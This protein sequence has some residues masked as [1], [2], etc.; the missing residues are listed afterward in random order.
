M[1]KNKGKVRTQV[2]HTRP[3]PRS[4]FSSWNGIDT[5][6]NLDTAYELNREEKTEDV[7][8]TRTK[9]RSVSSFSRKMVKV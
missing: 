5:F 9:A 1:P 8:R 4:P 3:C 7:E 2:V 6:C